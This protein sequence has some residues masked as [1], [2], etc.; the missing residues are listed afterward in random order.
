MRT[1][2]YPFGF[3]A[4]FGFRISGFG[5]RV[6]M[7]TVN[8]TIDGRK[9][10]VLAGQTILQAARTV[11]LAVPTLCHV[12]G[13]EH[14]ASCFLCAVKI[15][16]RPNL[17]PSCATPAAE[18]MVVINDSDEVRSARK[19]S[20]ELLL[21]D[22]AGDCIGPCRTGCPARLDIPGFI[23]GIAVGDH[24]KA[25]QIVDYYHACDHL[26]EGCDAAWGES[27]PRSKAEFMRLKTL[28][29]EDDHGVDHI[30]RVL[31]YHRG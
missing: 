11:G 28:L 18:G 7:T 31:K 19:T 4:S 5:F 20:L 23:A 1:H 8:L 21:S 15:E 12:E 26:K 6:A 22:H 10:E 16:G 27:T 13:F 25:T 29:K 3:R 30:V 17:W 24:P 2:T 14:S 9:A